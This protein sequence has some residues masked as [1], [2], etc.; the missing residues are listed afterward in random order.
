MTLRAT[1]QEKIRECSISEFK[2]IRDLS[3]TYVK[4]GIISSYDQYGMFQNL[5]APILE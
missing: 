3:Q 5:V 4:D 1:I 2:K